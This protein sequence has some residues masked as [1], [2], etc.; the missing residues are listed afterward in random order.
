MNTLV[1]I[2]KDPDEPITGWRYKS[3]RFWNY[4]ASMSVLFGGAGVCWVDNKRP[5]V[6]YKKY[7]GPDWVADYDSTTCGTVISNH[8][9]FL[10]I[11][12]H[13]MC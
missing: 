11:P 8:C 3:M 4:I 12:L 7:L 10:D 2:G 1:C 9:C 6:C 5:K 13:T